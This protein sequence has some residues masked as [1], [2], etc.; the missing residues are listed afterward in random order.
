MVH[1]AM[2][3]NHW[4]RIHVTPCLVGQIGHYLEGFSAVLFPV[5]VFH[6]SLVSAIM[7]SLGLCSIHRVCLG[8]WWYSLSLKYFI[9]LGLL[10]AFF[11]HLNF[12]LLLE[13]FYFFFI[14]SICAH[15]TSISCWYSV[16]ACHSPDLT[17]V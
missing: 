17:S 6:S 9:S 8:H 1:P 13:S 5:F 14:L 7:H 15:I 12:L 2:L 10:G 11:F 3:V 16:R 4:R